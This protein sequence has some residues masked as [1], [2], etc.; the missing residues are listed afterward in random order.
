MPSQQA[1]WSGWIEAAVGVVL[2]VIIGLR[3]LVAETFDTSLDALLGSLEA[4]KNPSPVAT[5]VFD[6][7]ILACAVIVL[8]TRNLPHRRWMPTGLGAGFVLLMVGGVLSCM[9]AGQQ[10]LAIN[11]TID[12]LAQ[13]AL[14]A[15]LVQLL[16]PGRSTG[17]EDGRVALASRPGF[18]GAGYRRILLAVVVA[19]AAVQAYECLDQTI[20][21]AASIRRE[22][23]RQKAEGFWQRQ[24][25]ELDSPQ[26][27]L[28]ERRVYANEAHG[29]LAHSNVT[30]AYLVMCAFAAA[31]VTIPRLKRGAGPTGASDTGV[32]GQTVA[33]PAKPWATYVMA[34]VVLALLAAAATTR[35]RGAWAG[36]AV[37][38]ACWCVRRLLANRFERSPRRW[39]LLGW[40][41]VALAGAAVVGHGLY[42]GSL[43]GSSLNFRWQYWTASA[44]LIG[45]HWLTGVGRENFGREY[46]RYKTLDSPEEVANPHNLLVHAAAEWG[47]F[48]LAGVC[49]LLVGATWPSGRASRTVAHEAPDDVPGGGAVGRAVPPEGATGE[50]HRPRGPLRSP[51]SSRG[52]N[53][54]APDVRDRIGPYGWGLALGG[55]IFAVRLP[56]LDSSDAAFLVYRTALPALIWFGAFLLCIGAF[57]RGWAAPPSAVEAQPAIAAALVA[58]LAQESINFGL[59]VPGAGVTV[60]T[61]AALYIAGRLAAPPEIK[62]ARPDVAGGT[63]GSDDDAPNAALR[64]SPPW[65]RWA[66]PVLGSFG[67]GVAVVMI[68]PAIS[69]SAV[70]A[71]ARVLQ[72]APVRSPD[73]D[74]A[75][76]SLAYHRAAAA[77]PRDSTAHGELAEWFAS[78]A[79]TADDGALRKTWLEAAEVSADAAIAR[80][81]RS[82]GLWRL[83]AQIA[84]LL[85]GETEAHDDFRRSVDAATEATRLY[86]T[87]PPTWVLRGRCALDAAVAVST[88]SDPG[89]SGSQPDAASRFAGIAAESFQHAL[90]LDQ[91]RP[92]WEELRR[93]TGRQRAEVSDLLS[94]ARKL[95]A[96]ARQ[97]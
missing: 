67:L 42:H 75:P 12:W 88:G 83:K 32:G 94:A 96:D 4:L 64:A 87:D 58:F 22:Y 37:G 34:L 24:G 31:G 6:I 70:L 60:A 78:M 29:F 28:F 23:E 35:S 76:A 48:G 10:R 11:G 77:D 51:N 21:S 53:L 1:S 63:A 80:D 45:D 90:S 20:F 52:Q 8:W 54:A 61:L 13:V 95:H 49:A 50:M 97:P 68:A 14:A 57:D 89:A 47:M 81:L 62:S 38:A 16:L 46:L 7:V 15:T 19:S 25:V 91:Q 27:R 56:L 69:A 59:F 36:A 92:A 9:A 41:G 74:A 85:A 66:S 40:G 84:Q 30:G 33:A 5:L 73:P 18:A 93:F 86:P 71:E 39:V 3:P 43:P 55:A 79:R 26:V 17:A 2:A 82:T 72:Q 44:D 65:L